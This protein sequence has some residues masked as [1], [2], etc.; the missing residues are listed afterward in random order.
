MIIEKLIYLKQL[1]V[2]QANL[3]EKMINKSMKGLSESNIKLLE[4]IITTDEKKV[5][6]FELQITELC[7][8]I[9][10]LYH[11]EAKDLRF[12]LM[13]MSMTTDLERIGDCIV[14]V[15][16]SSIFLVER[17]PI[18]PYETIYQ[19]FA[20]TISMVKDSI[21]SFINESPELA[22]SV[23]ERDSIVDDLRDQNTKTLIEYMFNDSSSIERGLN[24]IRIANNLEKT[25]DIST[26]IAEETVYIAMGQVIK[27]KSDI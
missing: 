27:H 25:A 6:R 1:L 19:I 23:C 7:T 18:K 11:P 22:K 4:E 24:M 14:N 26:S 2:Q 5:N 13:C 15:A 8:N 17:P 20:V 10:A 16:E 12:V 3:V 21:N 9:I